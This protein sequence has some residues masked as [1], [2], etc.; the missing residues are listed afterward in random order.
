MCR[1]GMLAVFLLL[2]ASLSWAQAPAG[3]Y[4]LLPESAAVGVT[5]SHAAPPTYDPRKAIDGNPATLWHTTY[6]TR[7]LPPPP[8][9]L[10]LDL[11]APYWLDGM[12]YL[13]RQ[14]TSPNGTIA[15]YMLDV[16]VDGLT[17]TSLTQ[18]TFTSTD[19]LMRTVRFLATKARYVRLTSLREMQ[20]LNYA[21]AAE[22]RVY[23]LAVPLGVP[24]PPTG[25]TLT[26]E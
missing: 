25:L 1:L 16:S 9:W 14:D 21:S 6:V 7:P 10:M 11:G 15:D 3:P 5:A 23:G 13:P 24:V 19:K 17:W 20:G 8:Y 4:P 18:G 22:V 26:F 12:D 2:T